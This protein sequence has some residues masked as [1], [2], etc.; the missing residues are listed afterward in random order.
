MN[1]R[2]F[3]LFLLWFVLSALTFTSYAQEGSVAK[4]AQRAVVQSKLTSPGS[5]PF[6]LKAKIVETTNPDSTYKG[7][8][9]EYWISPEKWRRTIQSPGFSQTLI[10]NGDQISEQDTGDY[11][12]WWLNDLVT[13]LFD[14]M[15]MVGDLAPAN[16]EISTQLN[17]RK[18]QS[19]ICGRSATRVG[20]APVENSVFSGFCLEGDHGLLDYVL[21]PEYQARFRDYED[22]RDK[23][24][25]RR[26]VIVPEPGTTVEAAIS[27]LT[28][29]KSP[30]ESLFAIQQA[31]PEK[32]RLK[33]VEITESAIRKLSVS[34]PDIV[35]AGVR[36]GK[37][38]GV[39]SMYISVD[40]TGHVRETWPL[41]S[42]NPQ[43]DDGARE[44]VM[45]WQFKPASMNGTVAQL[46]AVL[47]FAFDTKVE[48]ALPLLSDDEAR[49][50]A[51]NLVEAVFPSDTPKGTEVKLR[52]SI[53]TS[54]TMIG[55]QNVY[56]LSDPIF[57]A[58]YRAVNQWHFRPYLRDGKPDRY[59]A[60]IVFRVN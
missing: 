57:G 56:K 23:K 31:T 20:I 42:D 47:T 15:P 40:R 48:N 25:A 1:M 4:A 44:Q 22:F 5:T 34:S 41:N 29:L 10:T 45:K 37:T 13:A 18:K 52:V 51:T 38:R 12:P 9:E 24:V 30:D 46:E 33:R 26:I 54:G 17:F 6:H 8:I 53:D 28:E 36:D 35:W 59:L 11:Y 3:N 39:L 55:V 27:D 2:L 43:L 50:M 32:D 21:T 7:E 14:P 60:D 19:T 58:A 16:Q 49:K